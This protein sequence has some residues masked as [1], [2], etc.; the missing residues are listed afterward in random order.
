LTARATEASR[1]AQHN[2]CPAH[3]HPTLLKI[4]FPVLQLW[5]R[6]SIQSHDDHGNFDSQLHHPLVSIT[7]TDSFPSFLYFA[8][9]KCL[10]N[11]CSINN[12][13]SPNLTVVQEI[14][15][16]IS[17]KTSPNTVV[18]ALV[19][20]DN[21]CNTTKPFMLLPTTLEGTAAILPYQS[22]LASIT[23]AIKQMK[24]QDEETSH[25]TACPMYP[26]NTPSVLAAISTAIT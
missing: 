26:T 8:G 10:F 3:T 1:T 11:A 13:S 20:D 23:A 18:N 12:P 22:E 4:N 5:A 25:K 7:S 16:R 15:T 19:N 14:P 21:D 2:L 9:F 24:K 17:Q 6:H